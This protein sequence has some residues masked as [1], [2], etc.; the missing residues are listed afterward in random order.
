[1]VAKALSHRVAVVGINL[2]LISDF[3]LLEGLTRISF[4]DAYQAPLLH[5]DGATATSDDVTAST[6]TATAVAFAQHLESP[7]GF[8]TLLQHKSACDP[9]RTILT[10]IELK[11]PD[12]S[13]SPA[14][15][16]PQ[17]SLFRRVQTVFKDT[18]TQL[19]FERISPG[20]L[21]ST[22]P[23]TLPPRL[24]CLFAARRLCDPAYDSEILDSPQCVLDFKFD[25]VGLVYNS[26]IE[27]SLAISPLAIHTTS[28]RGSTTVVPPSPTTPPL[29][30]R[31]RL[32]ADDPTSP[33]R[34]R[35]APDTQEYPAPLCS[36]ARSRGSETLSVDHMLD[37]ITLADNS[38]DGE[39]SSE[40]D[41]DEAR[42]AKGLAFKCASKEYHKCHGCTYGQTQLG[43]ILIHENAMHGSDWYRLGRFPCDGCRSGF[44]SLAAYNWHMCVHAESHPEIL[45]NVV[46]SQ[47]R[48]G[49]NFADFDFEAGNRS[50]SI[51]F[52]FYP[53]PAIKPGL[54]C[55]FDGCD[56]KFHFQP[57]LEQ[58][59]KLHSV[60]L[61]V[62]PMLC[63]ALYTEP[64]LTEML[65]KSS[66]LNKLFTAVNGT[67]TTR[68]D[69]VNLVKELIRVEPDKVA[70]LFTYHAIQDDQAGP[71]LV[72]HRSRV[73]TGRFSQKTRLHGVFSIAA[74][75]HRARLAAFGLKGLGPLALNSEIPTLNTAGVTSRILP[76]LT[77]IAPTERTKSA[78]RWK[79][80][81]IRTGPP[82]P[83]SS[84][85]ALQATFVTPS[86][87]DMCY[88]S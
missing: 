81:Q 58:H 66:S 18:P 4:A 10:T 17:K 37:G 15:L 83:K 54:Q 13:P 39:S 87:M 63:D 8:E 34:K 16:G 78:M 50:E 69:V 84:Q 77:K 47:H 71:L 57:H 19:E 26:T 42:P 46:Q 41:D 14:I 72:V 68:R 67:K 60:S 45:T 44:S 22:I 62:Q 9:A 27:E 30:K 80:K 56:Q 24:F 38:D 29:V 23:P 33:P 55:R 73:V 32:P 52:S 64:D 76:S 2:P 31:E 40:D 20:D 79:S 12:S 85:T 51:S 36:E 59:N 11:N 65:R 74:E 48:T 21:L 88:R 49:L 43:K 6:F 35:T 82:T 70:A 75:L 61:E 86:P 25:L 3:A 28:S 53:P 7:F 1:M 5:G